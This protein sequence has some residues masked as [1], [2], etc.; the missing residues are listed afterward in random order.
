MLDQI[1]TRFE[2]VVRRM[3][4]AFDGDISTPAGRFA[5]FWH[6]QI[7][8]HAFLR[9]FWTNLHQVAPGAWRSN[10]PDARRLRRYRDMGIRTVLSLRGDR[11]SSHFRL[12]DEACRALGL[13]LVSRRIRARKLSRPAALLALL[14]Q[15]ETIEKPFVMHCKSGSDRTGIAAALYLLHIEGATL[16]EARRMLHWRFIHFRSSASGVLDQMLDA[17]EADT[18]TDPMPI[19]DWIATRYDPAAIKAAFRARRH[20][21]R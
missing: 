7:V 8:D 1:K 14:D 5:A 6:F 3:S 9:I 20:R 10:Q 13:T 17:Y 21:S 19:R 12:E 16:A 18:M 2:A 4:D 15:F 11:G